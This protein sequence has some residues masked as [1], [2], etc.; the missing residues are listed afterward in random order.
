MAQWSGR[1]TTSLHT[2]TRSPSATLTPSRVLAKTLMFTCFSALLLVLGACAL[3]N[4]VSPDSTSVA[5]TNHQG[6]IDKTTP[7]PVRAVNPQ[8]RIRNVTPNAIPLFASIIFTPSTTYEQAVAIIGGDPY[9]WTC[10]EP[11][12]NIPPPLSERQQAFASTHALLIS[13]PV[14]DQLQRIAS[15]PSVVMVEGTPLYPCP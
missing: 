15:S 10:D 12:S 11:R 7:T 8:G 2:S 6:H 3:G 9:P 13:Y 4:A 5:V 14:W 1:L